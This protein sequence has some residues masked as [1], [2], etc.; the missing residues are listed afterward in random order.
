MKNQLGYILIGGS[1]AMNAFCSANTLAAASDP[2]ETSTKSHYHGA[3][4][5]VAEVRDAT[6]RFLDVS[7]AEAEGY[8]RFLGCTSGDQEGAMGIHYVNGNL[9]GDGALDARRP[10][11]LVYEPIRNGQLRLV[12]VEFITIAEAWDASNPT[13]P[14]LMGQ[15]FHYGDSPNRYGLPPFYALHVWAWK[16]NQKGMFTDWNPE[17][18]CEGYAPPAS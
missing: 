2:Q 16:N 7:V 18:S 1:I 17:V 3:V 4:G 15:L 6:R 10:E 14:V 5:L 8:S 13:P 11:V 12:A 9:V